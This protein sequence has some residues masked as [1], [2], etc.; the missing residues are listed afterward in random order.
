M[1]GEGRGG[2]ERAVNVE[3]AGVFIRCLLLKKQ[4]ALTCKPT[5]ITNILHVIIYKYHD[6]HMTV[7]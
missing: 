1:G 2:E 7:T 5:G 6:F 4:Q 3:K